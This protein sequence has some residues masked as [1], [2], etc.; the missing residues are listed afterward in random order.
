MY[1][2]EACLSHML[3]KDFAVNHF[4]LQLAALKLW[5]IVKNII[6]FVIL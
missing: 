4:Y 3:S 2:L 6:D 1:G 5:N